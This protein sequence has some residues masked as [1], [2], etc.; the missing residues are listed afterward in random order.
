MVRTMNVAPLLIQDTEIDWERYTLTDEDLARVVDTSTL[1]GKVIDLREG[2]GAHEG[3]PLPWGGLADLVRLKAGKLS[4]W[5]GINHHGKTAMLKQ[6]A[7]HWIRSGQKVCMASMEETPE[8]TML[9][10]VFQAMPND[11]ASDDAID[12]VCHWA[13]GKLWLY[14]QQRMMTTNRML[15]LISYAAQEKGC[16]H[17]ILDSLMRLGLAQD[18]YEGQRVFV[19][20]LT[21]YARQLGIHVHLVHHIVKADESVIPG[22]ESIRGTGA[23]NDQAD[24][25]FIIWRDM[26]ESKGMEDPDGVLVVAK[27]RGRPNWIG[28]IKLWRHPSG[29]FLRGRYDDPLQ[30]LTRL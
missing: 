9:D 17:F 11:K 18:D 24:H 6:L 25:V 28:R 13:S 3:I 20:H 30:F 23:I 29:Q 4:I 22:R 14:D 19:N 21:N 26:R 5:A 10:I 12:V 16:K 15:A 2:R 1:V 27:N 8:E 7:L